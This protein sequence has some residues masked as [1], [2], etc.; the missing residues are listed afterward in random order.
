MPMLIN[1]APVDEVV[2]LLLAGKVHQ[3]WSSYEL[4]S[5]LLTPA[6]AWQLQLGLPNGRLPP[7]L[8]EGAAVQL[9]IGNDLVMTGHI[10]DIEDAIEHGAH[11]LTLRGRDGAAILVDC[12]SPIFTRRQAT[13]AEIVADVVRPLGLS[14]IRIDAAHT[15]SSEKVSVQPG[16]SAWDTLR[17]AAEANGLWPWFEPD[18]TLVIGGPDYQHPPVAS[19]ILRRDGQGNNVVRLHRVRSMAG[20]F[21]EITV[22]GQAHGSALQAGRHAI[23]VV[24]RDSSVSVYRPRIVMD[25]DVDSLA[26]ARA[27]AHKLLLDARLQGLTLQ[28][29]VKGHRSS[30]GLLW[31][32]GQRL[33]V[34]SEPHDINGIYFLM[35]RRFSGGRGRPSQT[36]LTL[37]EDG[38]WVPDAHP[39]KSS[40]GKSKSKRSRA[41]NKAVAV[42]ASQSYSPISKGK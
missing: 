42:A 20:R 34:L 11:S 7:A 10:D 12:S 35:A 28:A 21:S 33:H 24:E 25:H 17:N 41:N 40:P 23:K 18:G 15:L 19:L 30:D 3:N 5:D 13:L 36:E 37:K 8:Q 31:T 2:S 1:A 39:R 26:A 4:D 27:R 14:Q 22:L 32:P 29:T 38:T 16:D 9:R 6:D